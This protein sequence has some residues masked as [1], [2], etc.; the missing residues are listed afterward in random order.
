MTKY[1]FVSSR[2]VPQALFQS[3]QMAEMNFAGKT[4]WL[5]S[6][7]KPQLQSV[8]TFSLLQV[9]PSVPPFLSAVIHNFF[10]F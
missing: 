2:Y 9:C 1:N 6:F 7:Q 10:F 8:S 3:L 5:A 4:V